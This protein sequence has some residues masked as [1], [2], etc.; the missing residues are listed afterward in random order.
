MDASGAWLPLTAA[1][2]GLFFA[3]QIAPDNPCYTTAEV[4]E[5]AGPVDPELLRVA[6]ERAYAE[7]EQLRVDLAVTADG[8]RQRVSSGATGQP[9]LT[10]FDVPDEA[11]AA[12]WLDA[13][14][15]VPL[16]LVGDGVPSELVRSALLR[17]PDGRCWWYHAAH[18]VVADGYAA[19]QLLRR[20]A[21]H[22]DAI[23]TGD[24]VRAEATATLAEVVAEDRAREDVVEAAAWDERLATFLALPGNLALAGRA[25]PPAPRAIREALVLG[26]DVQTAL[27]QGA[28]RLGVGWPDLVTAAVGTYLARMAGQPATRMGLP[29]MNRALPDVGQ[30]ASARTVCTAMNVLPVTVR[31]DATVADVLSATILEQRAVRA[32]S[33][34]RQERLQR[35]LERLRPGSQLFGAQL[36]L[37]PFDLELAL[38]GVPGTVRNLSAG[39]VEDMT[40]G[41]RGTPGRG[42]VVRLE[43][44]AHPDLYDASELAAHLDRLSAWLVTVATAGPDDLVADLPL[45]T[46]RELATIDAFNSTGRPHEPRTLAQRFVAAAEL[47]PDVNALVMGEEVRT[48]RQ[49]LHRARAIA[50]GLRARSVVAGDVVGVALPRGFGLYET[51]H[52]IQLLGA[53]YL[54]IDPDLPD[55]RIAMMLE[56]AGVRV[57]VDD[58]DALAAEGD[59]STVGVH[60]DVAGPAYLLFTSGST[61][62]PKG[63]LVGH[64]AI[65]NRLAWMQRHFALVPGERVLHKTPISFDVSVWELFWPLQVGATVVIAPLGAHREPRWLADLVVDGDVTTLHFV[66]SM[67]R[68]FLADRVSRERVRAGRVRSVV[69][70]GEALTPD[71][72]ASCAKWFGVAPTNLYGPTE[73]AVDVTV[74][75]CSPGDEGPVPIGRPID[76]TICQVLDPSLRPAPIGVVGELWLGGVQLADGYVGRP[77]LTAE[78]F[79][80]VDLPGGRRRLYRT[81]DLAAWRADGALR[82]LG[83]TDDQVKVRGQRIEIGEIEAAVAGVAGIQAVAAG[84]VDG[85]LV[86]WFVPG[87]GVPDGAELVRRRA[88]ETLPAS[89]LPSHFVPVETMPLGTSGKT[90]RARLAELTPPVVAGRVAGAP[91]TLLEERL[92]AV[93]GEVLGGDRLGPGADFFAHGGDSLGVLRLIARIEDDLG[94]RLSLAAV[95]DAPTPASLAQV[96]GGGSDVPSGLEDVLTLRA[97]RGSDRSPLFLLPPAGGLG[98]SYAGLLRSLP[99]DQPVHALQASGI[100]TGAP[101][102]DGDLVA[103]ATRQ[104]AAIRRVV[105]DG[106]FHV[107]GWSL[108]GMAA[109]TVAALAREG[110]QEVGAVLLLDA[111]PSDQWQHLSM[112]TEDEALRGILRMGGVESLHPDDQP[113]DRA[114]VADVLRDGGSALAELPPAVLAGCIASVVASAKIVRASSHLVLDGDLDIVVAT[115]PRAETGLDAAG[116]SSYTK[117]EVRVHPVA[118]AHGDLVRRPAVDTIGSLM[119]ALLA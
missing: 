39:P 23:L 48:Y 98:W 18:H 25:A 82:Y 64:A 99:A 47:T 33:F 69:C 35:R 80:D 63:V 5:L 89:W 76:N 74:W 111:Y 12:A 68:A 8:P 87:A 28:R 36:N 22:Y 21:A 6:H 114:V 100:D 31:A 107:A 4:V 56:D 86:V 15:A 27:V 46:A 30:L 105:G 62:R 11:A 72:V 19:Q 20:I 7:H 3:H 101:L 109:H 49:L 90:D 73:A 104:L 53:V 85:Q 17:L 83:R 118:A 91:G 13:D 59:P 108:G 103:L 41:L 43:V 55:A 77:D 112:P 116:W 51:I 70:S 52:A 2:Q 50:A 61:G 97:A 40:I 32:H 93:F 94:V 9:V 117:G 1:Q 75:D 88:A 24:V 44:D 16:R 119:A 45:T 65:D 57:V 58:P 110:G 81:G 26:D 113:L 34:M 14:L 54:P 71:L 95:F 79:V 42:R 96:V 67:L 60:D 10:V 106:S 84:V 78:R 29:L 38:G 115:A 102:L 66:P 37:I 92:C